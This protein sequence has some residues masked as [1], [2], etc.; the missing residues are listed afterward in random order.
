MKAENVLGEFDCI[1]LALSKVS[2][3]FKD[4]TQR[5]LGLGVLQRRQFCV[6]LENLIMQIYRIKN[7]LVLSH[8]KE[9]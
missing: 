3:T 5:S 8:F 1:L 6:I 2:N 4:F 9:C 7:E